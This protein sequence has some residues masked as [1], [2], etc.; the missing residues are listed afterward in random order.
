MMIVPAAAAAASSSCPYNVW[1]IARTTELWQL[2]QIDDEAFPSH[3]LIFSQYL[4][5]SVQ[6]RFLRRAPALRSLVGPPLLRYTRDS[7]GSPH[8]RRTAA[9]ARSHYTEDR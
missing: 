6:Q 1:L 9:T 3:E 2:V 4:S 8:G 7:A 5:Y